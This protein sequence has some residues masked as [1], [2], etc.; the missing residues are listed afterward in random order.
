MTLW[1]A[2]T[3]LAAKEGTSF[4]E[5]EDA[6]YVSEERQLFAVA[7]GATEAFASRYWARFLVRAWG[8]SDLALVTRDTFVEFAGRLGDRAQQRWHRKTLAWYAEE[9]A[10]SGSFAAFAG[11]SIN[12]DLCEG[13][14]IGDCCVFQVRGGQIVHATPFDDPT[15]FSYR[16]TLLPTNRKEQELA[17]RHVIEFEM[18]L[19][20]MDV[21]YLMSDAIACW[22]LQIVRTDVPKLREF[23]HALMSHDTDRLSATVAGERRSGRMRNDD[24][25][26]IRVA[27]S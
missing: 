26:V 14:A 4:A 19:A 16:P 3:Y 27:R 20:M 15:S 7:D 25:A 13:V 2:V 9:K 24:V 11:I 12:S 5:C 10:R 22:F 18:S 17:E 21:V 23:D 8:R 6:I 1:R